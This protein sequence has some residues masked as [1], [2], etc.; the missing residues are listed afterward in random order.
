MT[1]HVKA[2]S[3]KTRLYPTSVHSYCPSK[4]AFCI[5]LPYCH[6]KLALHIGLLYC[7][8]KLAFR[9]GLLYQSTRVSAFQFRLRIPRWQVC[10]RDYKPIHSHCLFLIYQDSVDFIAVTWPFCKSVKL[11]CSKQSL[12]LI[13]YVCFLKSTL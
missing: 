11:H 9:I 6:S 13:I 2:C 1:P 10:V 3:E 8:S 4:L 7:H 5:G 12:V